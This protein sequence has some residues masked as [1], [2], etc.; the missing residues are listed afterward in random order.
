MTDPRQDIGID[1][2]KLGWSICYFE[3]GRMWTFDLR[4]KS[5]AQA[6]EALRTSQ[7]GTVLVPLY[8]WTRLNRFLTRWTPKS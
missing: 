6:E 1:L 4:W 2:P 7:A 8:D 3:R 5:R